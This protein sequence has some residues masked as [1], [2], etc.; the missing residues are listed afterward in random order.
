MTSS[1]ATS[2]I[3]SEPVTELLLCWRAG[4]K[5]CLNLLPPRMEG[6][7][8]RIGRHSMKVEREGHTP[9][10]TALVNEAC[11]KLVDQAQ[12]NWQSRA[13]FMGVGRK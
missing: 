11:L 4:D 1:R 6:E 5:D 2:S 10:T 3:E 9:Q 13:Q 12:V 8:R 7:P